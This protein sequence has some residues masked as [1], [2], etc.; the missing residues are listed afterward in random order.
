MPYKHIWLYAQ[1][2]YNN[3]F[4]SMFKVNHIAYL[5]I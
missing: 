2:A 5:Y 3:F 1:I 4:T